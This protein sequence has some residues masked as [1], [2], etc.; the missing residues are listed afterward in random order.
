MV[1]FLLYVVSNAYNKYTVKAYQTANA[2]GLFMDKDQYRSL[3]S[4]ESVYIEC[5]GWYFYSM[6]KA[7]PQRA[8]Y[9]VFEA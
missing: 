9:A 4:K 8:S 7:K 6:A 3:S 2:A 1:M 5:Q